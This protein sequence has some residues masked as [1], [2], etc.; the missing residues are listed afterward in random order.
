MYEC[1]SIFQTLGDERA[2]V[3]LEMALD[4]LKRTAAAIDDPEMRASFLNNVPVNQQLRAASL[5]D[6]GR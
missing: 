1:Y 2:A 6:F 3:A 4:V 5:R